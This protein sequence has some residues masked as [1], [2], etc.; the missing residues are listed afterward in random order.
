MMNV[1]LEHALVCWSDARQALAEAQG[2]NSGQA[3]SLALARA[4]RDE[5]LSRE[6]LYEALRSAI[7]E[8]GAS[9]TTCPLRPARSAK[10]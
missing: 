4:A 8:R 3:Y 2:E 1:D 9:T 7:G 6:C 5:S 10:V